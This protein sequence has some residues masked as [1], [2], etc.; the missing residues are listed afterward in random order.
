MNSVGW[1]VLLLDFVAQSFSTLALLSV[2]S[3]VTWKRKVHSQN[4]QARITI[5]WRWIEDQ[6]LEDK[7]EVKLKDMKRESALKFSVPEEQ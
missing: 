5:P 7:D 1:N 2:L 6:D 3:M 4:G